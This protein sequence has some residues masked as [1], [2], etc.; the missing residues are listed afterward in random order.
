MHTDEPAAQL[1]MPPGMLPSRPEDGHKG[2]FGTAFILAGQP[3]MLGA[4]AFCASAALAS[5]VGLVRIATSY[6]VMRDA[7]LIEPAATG[8]A[9]DDDPNAAYRQIAEACESQNNL[10][11]AIGPGLGTDGSRHH[12][13]ER[14]IAMRKPTVIDAD[15]LNSLARNGMPTLHASCI[16]T[17]HPGEFR[18]LA[19]ALNLHADPIDATKRP[20]A[21]MALAK[22]TQ[23]VV[24][25]K[26][27]RTIVADPHTAQIYENQ[28]GNVV[29]A[30]GGSGDVL[31]GII[32]GLLAQG[33]GSFDAACWAS[34][35]HGL[36]GDAWRDANGDRGLRITQLI[37]FIPRVIRQCL[38]N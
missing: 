17:P 3:H 6:Q 24:L 26:G 15:G 8:I 35:L 34:Y 37:E 32:V 22:Q 9:L 7:L 25:L 18:R 12:L 19:K 33:M 38:G 1:T 27:R 31:T 4:P 5:G 28:T 21:A 14:L 13:I 16:L 20:A 2:T 30:T 23:A 29:L 36:A 10:A 11:L